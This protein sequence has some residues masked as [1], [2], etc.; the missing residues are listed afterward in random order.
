MKMIALKTLRYGTRSL[1]AGD[2]FDASPRDAKLLKVIGKAELP[3]PT[4]APKLRPVRA[5]PAEPAATVPAEDTPPLFD[6]APAEAAPAS[7]D[8][9][10]PASKRAY[11]RRDLRA[12]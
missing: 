8:S 5:K 7:P 3:P 12:E 10:P 2:E 4:P 1:R 6:P 11:T 9:E